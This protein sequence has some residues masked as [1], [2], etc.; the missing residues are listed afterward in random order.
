M[1]IEAD[2]FLDGTALDI[3]GGGIRFVSGEQLEKDKDIFIVLEIK[4]EDQTKT[5][6]LL[7]RVIMS[8]QAKSKDNLF[9]HRV[10]FV[11]MQGGVRESLIKYIFEEERRQR[12]KQ[13]L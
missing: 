5:Y 10:E 11:N 2:D 9:E 6:G 4:Y 3:S 12:Q 8:Y 13:L 7:G 1:I